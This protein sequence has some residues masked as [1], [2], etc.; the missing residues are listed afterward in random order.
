MRDMIECFEKVTF[1]NRKLHERGGSF[2]VL[3]YEF[4]ITILWKVW[5][6]GQTIAFI[7]VID[8]DKIVDK[9]WN[10]AVLG[11]SCFSS[12]LMAMA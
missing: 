4:I 10:H 5:K 7:G 3:L 6:S 11:L 8:V 12:S 2:L 1:G 9:L